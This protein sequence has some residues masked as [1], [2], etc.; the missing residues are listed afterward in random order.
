MT[1][2]EIIDR[3][4][5]L[6]SLVEQQA[7]T[8]EKQQDQIERQADTIET[9]RERL[10]EI[11]N[12]SGSS[13]PISR[14]GTM[15]AAGLLGLVGLGAGTASA[16]GSG[17]VGTESTPVGTVFTDALDGDVT[18]DDRTE[19]IDNLPG[20]IYVTEEGAE[21]PTENDGDIWFEY[22]T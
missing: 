5:R 22:E 14:R 2:Q 15:Q 9:Q 3:L 18:S 16:S 20:N 11:E 6:E 19:P 17:T 4:D 7:E 21:D 12:D 8:I 13:M 1:D 10:A